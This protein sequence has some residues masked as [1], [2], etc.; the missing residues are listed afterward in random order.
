MQCV[1]SR[2]FKLLFYTS[3]VARHK[4]TTE[5]SMRSQWEGKATLAIKELNMACNYFLIYVESVVTSEKNSII[6]K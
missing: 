1:H 4:N 3:A 5:L 2:I 6:N